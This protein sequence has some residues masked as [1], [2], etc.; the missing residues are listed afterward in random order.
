MKNMK[1]FFSVFAASVAILSQAAGFAS[2][3][4]SVD[5]DI[6]GNAA[7][8]W[9]TYVGS[10]LAIQGNAKVGSSWGTPQTI[11]TNSNNMD[12]PKIAV[13]ANGSD[14]YAVAIWAEQNGN[15][16]MAL[17]GSML[18]DVSSGWTSPV[19]ISVDPESV[20]GVNQYF[21]RINESGNILAVWASVDNSN[22]GYIR[23]A[24][25]QIS[26][27]NAWNTPTYVSGP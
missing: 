23:S 19:Q 2:E 15:N 8:V 9:L 25:A 27:A 3:G 18:P 13:A 1:H 12:F 7:A 21:V 22:N 24:T 5:Q 26:F 11:S 16:Y 6:N 14:I 4:P 17:M 10:D 20:L